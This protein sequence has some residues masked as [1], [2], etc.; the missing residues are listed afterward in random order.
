ML[1]SYKD[2]DKRARRA[3]TVGAEKGGKGFLER[4]GMFYKGVEL[5]VGRCRTT[6]YEVILWRT[7]C[8]TVAALPIRPQNY[9]YTLTCECIYVFVCGCVCT[10]KEQKLVV[11]ER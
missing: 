7:L 2:A 3:E 11:S 4:M 10:C 6:K 9:T 5:G 8:A 1:R